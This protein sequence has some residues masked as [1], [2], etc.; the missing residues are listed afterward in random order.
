[1][2]LDQSAVAGPWNFASHPPQWLPLKQLA[3]A[4]IILLL[5]MPDAGGDSQWP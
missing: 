5:G 1:M 2:D 4:A 3:G